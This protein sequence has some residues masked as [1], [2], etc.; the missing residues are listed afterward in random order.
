MAFQLA[1]ETKKDHDE[2]DASKQKKKSRTTAIG[3][4]GGENDMYK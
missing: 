2:C 3:N 4:F 1:S